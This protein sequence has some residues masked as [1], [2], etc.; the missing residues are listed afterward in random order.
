MNNIPSLGRD[1][2]EAIEGAVVAEPVAAWPEPA[3]QWCLRIVQIINEN[4]ARLRSGVKEWSAAGVEAGA[5]AREAE[6]LLP[7]ADYQL[8][9]V[10][11][12]L[13]RLS[14]AT[15]AAAKRLAEELQSLAVETR[16][17]R[18]WLYESL[19]QTAGWVP[20]GNG[21]ICRLDCHTRDGRAQDG[22]PL[23]AGIDIQ[24]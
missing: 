12:I 16:S 7:D 8:V 21:R 22:A 4:T 6:Q 24:P 14:Q 18:Y 19:P 2:L 23:V 10:Q 1:L 5:F 11:R 9:Q 17:Y 3:L 13:G 20:R 15:D